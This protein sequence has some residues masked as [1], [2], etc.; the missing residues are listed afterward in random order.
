MR[1]EISDALP[2]VVV[3]SQ[4][5]YQSPCSAVTSSSSSRA[6]SCTLQI[7]TN[8]FS[9]FPSFPAK[10]LKMACTFPSG[11]NEACLTS[12]EVKTSGDANCTE[13]S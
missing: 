2:L 9:P 4:S 13:P 6:P 12:G 5:K 3:D 8:F 11:E 10:A 7:S 1:G